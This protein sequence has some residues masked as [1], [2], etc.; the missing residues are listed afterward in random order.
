[1]GGGQRC[2]YDVLGLE[3]G[4][5]EEAIKKAYRKQALTWHPGEWLGLHGRSMSLRDGMH[6]TPAALRSQGWLRACVPALRRA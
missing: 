1:M 3:P 6:Q 2:L 4:A 5:D